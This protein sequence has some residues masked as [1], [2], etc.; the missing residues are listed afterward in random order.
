[1]SWPQVGQDGA[2]RHTAAAVVVAVVAGC[3]WICW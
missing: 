2:V 3:R 1:M